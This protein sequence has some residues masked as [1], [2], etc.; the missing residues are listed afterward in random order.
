MNSNYPKYF[1]SYSARKAPVP[2][3]IE[4]FFL[5]WNNPTSR[6]EVK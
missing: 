5:G 2:L 6:I 1:A 4:H 3:R